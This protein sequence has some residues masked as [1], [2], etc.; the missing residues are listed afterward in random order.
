AVDPPDVGVE[1][2]SDLARWADGNSERTARVKIAFAVGTPWDPMRVLDRYE[3]LFEAGLV[4]EADTAS[5]G[6]GVEL[7][8]DH[9]R[10]VATALGR[11]R[12]KL[13]YRPVIFEVMPE[14]FTLTDLQ[15]AVEAI[16]GVQ[17]HKQNFRRTIDRGRLVEPSGGFSTL[18]GGRPAAMYRFR[19]DV[20]SERPRPGFPLPRP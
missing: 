1:I 3:L 5:T 8:K 12:G 7:G 2:R 13:T 10:I 14:E 19:S 4:G 9:R 16:I 20:V 15:T 6:H 11:L 17:L 18:T